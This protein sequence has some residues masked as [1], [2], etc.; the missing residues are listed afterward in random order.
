[1]SNKVIFVMIVIGIVSGEALTASFTDGFSIGDVAGA[2]YWVA[3]T[4]MIQGWLGEKT[5]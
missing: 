4:L 2:S 1:M 5:A 3:A